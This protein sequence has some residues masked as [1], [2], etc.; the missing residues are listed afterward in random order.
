MIKID[1]SKNRSLIILILLGLLVRLPLIFLP[2]FKFDVD[3]WFAW[4]IR[5][6][7]VNFSQFYSDQIWTNY[8]PG[9]LYILKLLGFIKSLL[10]INDD[11]FYL[12]L[13]IPSIIS[14]VI[15]GIFLY[16]QIV[17]RS[18]IWARLSAMLIFFNPAFIF[19]SSIWGQIDGLLSLIFVISIYFLNKR[20]I[21]LSSIFLGLGFLIKPQTI[22]LVPV[23]ILFLV[24][25][26]SFK[27]FLQLIAP[28]V[29][30]VFLLS[31]PFFTDKP[32]VGLPKLF[33][34]M[35]SDYPQT[36]L[37]AYN[38]WGVAGFWIPD[39]Y[40][41]L[42]LSY[43]YW[44]YILFTS[45][46]IVVV[47]LYLTKRLPFYSLATLAIL[48]FFFLPTRVHER[49]LFP[50]IVFLVLAATT[51]KSK[52]LILLTIILSL[53]HF[54]NL[55]YVYIYYNYLYLKLPTVIYNPT[56]YSFLDGGGKS[57]S[58]ISTVIFILISITLFKHNVISKK[59]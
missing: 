30:T 56:F 29:L 15:L 8:T 17:K 21:I 34:K 2:G 38:F 50:A 51:I 6:N 33:S 42:S 28:S 35:V 18:L 12:V 37:F 57:L 1:I 48:G 13:K 31:L 47:Y 24:K 39:N 36:S 22:A 26:F 3:A 14:E 49:Y 10:Q 23:F 52:S 58:L 59:D 32:L 46:W 20:K 16:Q 25:N 40:S 27:N 43:R 45:Y 5:L 4:A 55:Y 19:N 44:G 53:L 9:F 7:Q 41:F 11:N 54:F